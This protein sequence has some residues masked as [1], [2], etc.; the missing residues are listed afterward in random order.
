VLTAGCSSSAAWRSYTLIYGEPTPGVEWTTPLGKRPT[1]WPNST[2]DRR[3]RPASGERGTRGA[4][5][6]TPPAPAW[7]TER[8]DPELFRLAREFGYHNRDHRRSAV[9][10]EGNQHGEQRDRAAA[11]LPEATVLTERERGLLAE[12]L[13]RIATAD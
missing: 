5:D 13:D 4:V 3:G 9:R 7:P 11:V 6:P 10:F 2:A 12:W 8:R 1:S